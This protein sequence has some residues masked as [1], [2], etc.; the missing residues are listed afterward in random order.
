MRTTIYGDE[1]IFGW[2]KPN[3]NGGETAIVV[4][5]Y[6]E[7]VNVVFPENETPDRVF[8]YADWLDLDTYVPREAYEV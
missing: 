5:T 1:D 3:G 8:D 6:G 2:S 4:D 7:E